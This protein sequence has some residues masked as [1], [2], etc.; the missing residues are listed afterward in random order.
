M[1]HWWGRKSGWAKAVT[2]LAVLL[3]V[4]MGL[5]FSTS[6]TVQPLYDALFGPSSG[7]MPGLGLVI[8]QAM[9]CVVTV[10]LLFIAVI[11]AAAGGHFSGKSN[12]EGDLHD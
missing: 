1:A 8:V 2:A 7:E 5:C 6:Y 10:V 12:S 3:I 9:L 4:Q 11:V